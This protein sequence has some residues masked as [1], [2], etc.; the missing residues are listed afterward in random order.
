MPNSLPPNLPAMLDDLFGPFFGGSHAA[1]LSVDLALTEAEAAS[2]VTRDVVFQRHRAC[3]ACEGRGS[4]NPL[5]VPV[6]CISCGATGKREVT[7]G[8]FKVQTACATCK[9]AGKTM[10]EPCG[11]CEAWGRV[12]ADATVSVVVPANVEHG[13]VLTLE[14]EGS[15]GEAGA[16]GALFVNV[17][18]G[19]RPDPRLAMLAA[20]QAAIADLPAAQV[21]R[22]STPMPTWQIAAIAIVALALL[23]ALLLLR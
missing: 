16:V 23:A 8:F 9:G 12:L 3:A 21:H 18:V 11:T 10:V 7:Q 19:G 2:G 4:K 1:N 13:H 22:P 5:A 6:D 17:L 20:H 15:T 14:G